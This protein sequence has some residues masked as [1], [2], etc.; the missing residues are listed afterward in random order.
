M[1]SMRRITAALATALLAVIPQARAQTFTGIQAAGQLQNSRANALPGWT[2]TPTLGIAGTTLGTLSLTGNTSGTVVIRPQAAAGSP[3]LTLPNASGTF[4]ISTSGS[5]L[6]LSATTGNL[7][8]PGA[9]KT[10]LVGSGGT[11]SAF[12]STPTVA[13][14][15]VN[16]NAASLSA[17]ASGTLIQ[18]GN[19]DGNNTLLL[20]DAFGTGSFANSVQL[21]KARNTAASPQAIQTDDAIG[22][23]AACGFGATVYCTASRGIFAWF[24]GETW[25]DTQQGTYASFYTTATG[26]TSTTEKLRIASDGTLNL[27]VT[28]TVLG[29]LAF[30]GNTSGTVSVQ[31]Q[32]AAGTWTF[33][34]PNGAGT[35]KFALKTDGAGVASWAGVIATVA[36][37]KF[38]AG[39]TYTPTTGIQYAIIECWGAGGGGGGSATGAANTG[40][41]AAGGGAGSYSRAY[42]SAA[43]IGASQT[44]T[45]G[46]AG[47]GGA[48]GNNNGN[49]GT[50]TSVGTLCV[51]KGGSGGGGS[52]GTGNA[53]GGLGGIAGTGDVTTT[54]HPGGTAFAIGGNLS[55][56]IS[57]PGGTS[58]VGGGGRGVTS[59]TAANGENATGFAAGGSGG[60][61]FNAGGTAS[62]GNGTAGYVVITEYVL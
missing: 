22:S 60:Q 59:A 18:I 51:G 57:G 3:T 40:A 61:S 53:T 43:T 27:G 21:R 44:V 8:L 58:P 16:N 31:P 54:G 35:N 45:I 14:L 41:G 7:T 46:T 12:S 10:V 56:S 38:T 48:A 17:G 39:G 37:Q 52:A 6:A 34:W 9:T 33:K 50:D 5:P 55:A 26:G 30:S 4:A 23:L 25:S 49:A 62:G 13:T 19:A 47:T 32:A 36:V 28:G 24:A 20:L 15:T 11:G 1:I 42:A 29:K 2:A